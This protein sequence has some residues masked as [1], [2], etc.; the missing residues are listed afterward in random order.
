MGQNN[1]KMIEFQPPEPAAGKISIQILAY[2]F[3]EHLTLVLFH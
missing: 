3:L 1:S 2:N